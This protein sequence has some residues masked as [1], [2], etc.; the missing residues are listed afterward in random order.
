[1]AALFQSRLDCMFWIH[2]QFA[3][4]WEAVYTCTSC[5]SFLPPTRPK[6]IARKS[7]LRFQSSSRIGIHFSRIWQL[8]FN[9]GLIVCCEYTLNLQQAEREW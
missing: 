5:V 6:R 9:Q 3:A 4:D 2:P 8:C 7:S 1:M